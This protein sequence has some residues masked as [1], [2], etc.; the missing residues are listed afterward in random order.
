M[1]KTLNTRIALRCDSTANW[2][3]NTSAVLLKGELGI[4]LLA[5]NSAKLKI[6][7]G[8]KTWATLPYF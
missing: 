5:D 4:E 2:S 7:D 6:G 1:S 3:S 8:S